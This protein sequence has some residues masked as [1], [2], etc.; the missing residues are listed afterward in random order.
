MPYPIP[1]KFKY[2]KYSKKDWSEVVRFND[3][4]VAE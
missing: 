2:S 3:Y 1:K 4:Q